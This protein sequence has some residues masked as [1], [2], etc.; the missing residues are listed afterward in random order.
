MEEQTALHSDS[1]TIWEQVDCTQRLEEA[2]AE[3]TDILTETEISILTGS[4]T[5]IAQ[6]IANPLN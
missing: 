3:V 2:T 5:H 6:P 1:F 4:V